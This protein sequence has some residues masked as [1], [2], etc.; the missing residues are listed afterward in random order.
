MYE[1][2]VPGMT[3]G[4]CIQRVKQ[5]IQTSDAHAEVQIDLS[6]KSVR[7]RSCADIDA[8]RRSLGQAGYPAQ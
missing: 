5:A 8:I 6:S 7:V 2:R 4:H 3:C 1:L